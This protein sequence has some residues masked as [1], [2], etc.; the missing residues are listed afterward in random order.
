MKF[1]CKLGIHSF[2]HKKREMFYPY[3]RGG[4]ETEQVIY[5]VGTKSITH[6]DECCYCHKVKNME[7]IKL[8][9]CTQ[10]LYKFPKPAP[11]TSPRISDKT[12]L[13]KLEEKQ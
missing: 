3:K 2:E 11:I 12:N 9:R 10:L 13:W 8:G 5:S 6:Y 7:H 1:L 4:F